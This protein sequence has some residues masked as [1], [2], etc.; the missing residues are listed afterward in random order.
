MSSCVGEALGAL[1]DGELTP[2]EEAQ[3]RVHLADC[4]RCRAEL[5]ATE[6]VRTLVRGLPRL[7]LPSVVVARA[8][9]S[10]RRRSSRAAAAAAA[11]VAVAAS[12]LFLTTA[13]SSSSPVTPE[14]DRLVEVHATSGATADPVSR[15]TPAAV[16]VSFPEPER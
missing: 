16:P 1:L 3:V 7:D 12:V 11:A 14:V 4:A 8:R 10:A 5:V 13:S 6:Q 2:A 15:L 9:W